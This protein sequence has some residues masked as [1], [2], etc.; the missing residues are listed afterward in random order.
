[1]ETPHSKGWWKRQSQQLYSPKSLRQEEGGNLREILVRPKLGN[2][3]FNNQMFQ[4]SSKEDYRDFGFYG[5][6]WRS[7]L[8]KVLQEQGY[9]LKTVDLGSLQKAEKILFI[10]MHRDEYF[11]RCLKL[12]LKAKMVLFEVEFPTY[13]SSNVANNG[14]YPISE[15][16]R[17]FGRVLTWNEEIVDNKRIFKVNLP[18]NWYNGNV[19]DVSFEDRKL[20]VMIASKKHSCHP[21]E[22]YSER[23]RAILFFQENIPKSFDLYGTHWDRSLVRFSS[24][25]LSFIDA[26]GFW[27]KVEKFLG[28]DRAVQW[29]M[30]EPRF[31][32]FR[33]Y[34][35]NKYETMS[36]YRFVLCYENVGGMKGA[37]SAKIFSCFQAR[38]VPVYL[39]APNI[40]DIVPS[41]T[42]IDKR[43]FTYPELLEYL[44]SIEKGEFNEFLHNIKNFLE[45]PK[46]RVHFEKD[47]GRNFC[48][49]LLD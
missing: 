10:S 27:R 6:Q 7:A 35:S 29:L 39:G 34:S 24:R 5:F 33:G 21:L 18:N 32:T 46:G 30:G 8:R 49:V 14:D 22:L 38:C 20:L 43:K 12:G 17:E 40:T 1:M 31:K 9:G 3:P 2:S 23:E 44:E 42:F 41:K 45:S 16:R 47:W 11:K 15:Y 36:N 19:D 4:P 25:H 13:S 48:E 28:I 26:N 37:V